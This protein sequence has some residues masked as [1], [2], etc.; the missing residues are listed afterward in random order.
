MESGLAEE[1][2]CGISLKVGVHPEGGGPT[3]L[4]GDVNLSAVLPQTQEQMEPDRLQSQRSCPFFCLLRGLGL[5]H[6]SL[7]FEGSYENIFLPSGSS[8]ALQVAG[9]FQRPR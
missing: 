7:I 5:F 4:D 1:G 8:K 3:A 2:Y 9:L 6:C